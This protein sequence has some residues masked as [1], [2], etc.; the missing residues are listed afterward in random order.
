MAV[1]ISQLPIDVAEVVGQAQSRAAGAVVLF[2][3]TTREWTDGRR[4]V[5]LDYDCYGEMAEPLLREL[6]AEARRRWTLVD[7]CIVHRI[8]RV[9]LGE[10]SVAIAVSAV[11]RQDA[12][13]A[14]QWLI[15]TIKQQV[16]IWKRETWADGTR[17][18]VH[19]GMPSDH[20]QAGDSH[21]ARR[22]DS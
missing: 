14:A 22:I 10:V 5:A 18:W 19:P 13:A 12:F 6:E 4:T 2:A 3:G 11:H 9:D 7:T 21:P 16:P 17:Q 8:G 1:R 20:G 15:D